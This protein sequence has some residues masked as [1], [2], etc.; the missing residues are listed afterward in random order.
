M[1]I[2]PFGTYI[3]TARP[4]ILSSRAIAVKGSTSSP[5]SSSHSF[6]GNPIVDGCEQR[7]L[8]CQ[9]SGGIAAP[10]DMAALVDDHDRFSG[11]LQDQAETFFF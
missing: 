2:E 10:Q 11:M 1:A 7:I 8:S 4:R 6:T 5:E 9:Q 3:S